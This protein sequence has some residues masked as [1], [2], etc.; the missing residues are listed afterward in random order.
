MEAL[1]H[2]VNQFL[3]QMRFDYH[4]KDRTEKMG[5]SESV[6]EGFVMRIVPRPDMLITITNCILAENTKVNFDFEHDMVELTICFQGAGE[7]QA[8]GVHNRIRSN[9]VTLGLMNRIKGEYLFTGGQPMITL[10]IHISV[11]TFNHFIKG[12]NVARSTDFHQLL[13]NQSLLQFQQ[14]ID[15]TTSQLARQ[16]MHTPFI[17]IARNIELESKALELLSLSFQHFIYDHKRSNLPAMITRSEF[18]K[19]QQAKEVLMQRMEN[20]PSLLE[21]SRIIGMNDF[22]LKIS[23][24][25]VFCTTVFGYLREKRLEKAMLLLQS[26]KMSVSEAAANVGYTNA[27]Y[28]ANAFRKRYGINPSELIRRPLTF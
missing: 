16:I 22:K 12:L 8:A 4:T 19:L 18:E 27:S 20:P 23:F 13:G 28:F 25:E 24:K 11:A 21:L 2:S 14:A 7:V 3:N 26:G 10:G 17:N 5:F 9:T 6:G 15:V 1:H